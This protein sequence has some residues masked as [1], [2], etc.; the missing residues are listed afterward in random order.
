MYY[1]VDRIEEEFA[2]CENSETYD[3]VNIPLSELPE[4]I[5]E[6]NCIR[7]VNDEYVRDIE[8]E[9]QRKKDLDDKINKAWGI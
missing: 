1:I 4:G 9:E 3:M 5:A 8:L 6:G 7:L 2:V